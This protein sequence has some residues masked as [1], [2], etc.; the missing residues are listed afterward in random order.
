MRLG[1]ML[2]IADPL[3]PKY[4]SSW[5]NEIKTQMFIIFL[6]NNDLMKI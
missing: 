1:F 2:R 6:E 3:K 5:Q 4:V